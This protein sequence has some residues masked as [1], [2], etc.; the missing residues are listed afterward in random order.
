MKIVL[1]VMLGIAIASTAIAQQG[2]G[3]RGA[4][5]EPRI[6][7]FE[8][9]PSSIRPGES[10]IAGVEHGE[11]VRSFHRPGG[12]AGHPPRKQASDA[13]CNDNVHPVAA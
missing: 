10:G 4:A 5:P 13:R 12:R 6:V 11:P 3:A 1:S 2:R 9:K 8:V 7:S